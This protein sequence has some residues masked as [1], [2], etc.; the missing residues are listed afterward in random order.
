MLK[1]K[2]VLK[3]IWA[4]MFIFCCVLGFLPSQTGAN[5]VLMVILAVLFFVVPGWLVWLSLQ[6]KDRATLKLVMRLSFLS[7][8]STM[9]LIVAN[10]LS[11]L[12]PT[13]LGDVLYYLLLVVST[14]MLCGHYW[15]LSLTL[16]AVLLWG[17]MLALKTLK[18]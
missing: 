14:P 7:L 9:V 13:W 12:G 4:G 15:V 3:A 16:W 17:S 8:L 11:V 2:G 5:R 18:T 6:D 10:L 1:D